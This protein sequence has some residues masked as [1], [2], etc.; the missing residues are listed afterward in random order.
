VVVG[1][2]RILFVLGWLTLTGPL[3]AFYRRAK[4]RK[5]NNASESTLSSYGYLL[6]MISYL[7]S[8]DPPVLPVLN[9]LPL[10]WDGRDASHLEEG[11]EQLPNMRV[12][13]ADGRLCN[14]YFYQPE[15]EGALRAFGSRNTMGLGELFLGFFW[16]MSTRFDFQRSVVSIRTKD[17]FVLKDTKIKE[18]S[19]RRHRRLSVED[20]FERYYDVAHPVRE[21][22]HRLI[23]AEMA[24]S[25]FA[26]MCACPVAANNDESNPLHPPP[27]PATSS[28][29]SQRIFALAANACETGVA[30][31]SLLAEIMRERQI[32]E[33]AASSQPAG[34]SRSS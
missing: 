26:Q 7:Q 20:P 3:F 16:H 22:K 14:V 1:F 24:V 18:D 29:R 9:L 23:R 8:V 31:D 34:D 5:L 12:P 13:S 10:D 2:H 4:Q 27:P 17:P 15:D 6:I 21:H 28:P 19:W 25:L 30:P 32:A 33:P 11:S